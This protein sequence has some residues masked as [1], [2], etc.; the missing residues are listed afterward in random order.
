MTLI[1]LH[2]MG[3]NASGWNETV[4]YLPSEISAVCPE[5]NDFF[6]GGEC[7]YSRL[8]GQFCEYLESFHEPVNLCGLSLGA[9]LALNY[10]ADRP[11]RVGS[12]IL[13]A[14]QYRMPK[15]LLKLQ[16]IIFKFMP[17]RSFKSIGFSRADFLTLTNSM[18]DID[19]TAKLPNISCPA[20]ILCG[21]KDGANKKAAEE[22]AKLIPNGDFAEIKKS[23]HEVNR[24]DPKELA[25]VISD[26]CR[27]IYGRD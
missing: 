21:E 10:A 24:D 8:Y 15:T 13:I 6:T 4:S 27:K 18:A 9:V 26:R 23:D 25:R 1:M 12:L 5:L 7:T 16:N 3:Q 2:G 19:M 14:P 20:L 17:D 22:L 11:E